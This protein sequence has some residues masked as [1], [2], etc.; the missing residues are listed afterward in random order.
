[1]QWKGYT[2]K[3]DTWEN[4]KNLENAKKMVEEFEREY[5][6]D[7]E[8]IWRQEDEEDKRLG[9]RELPGRYTAKL[10]YEWIDK[11]YKEE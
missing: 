5:R 11:K 6:K 1:M 8:E 3:A 7:K 2:A 4:R 10:L 9:E